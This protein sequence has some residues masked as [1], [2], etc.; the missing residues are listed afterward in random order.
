LK[1]AAYNCTDVV[2]SKARPVY[3]AVEELSTCT[4]PWVASVPSDQAESTPSRVTKIKLAATGPLPGA[5]TGKGSGLI[6]LGAVLATIPVQTPLGTPPAPGTFA[7][8]VAFGLPK[9]TVLALLGLTV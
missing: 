4:N 2:P 1:L 6:K 5:V 7:W 3:T 8:G 9:A